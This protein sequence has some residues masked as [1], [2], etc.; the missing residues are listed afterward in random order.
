MFSLFISTCGWGIKKIILSIEN[1]RVQPHF[2]SPRIKGENIEN[3]NEEQQVVNDHLI[4]V[5]KS[6][7]CFECSLKHIEKLHKI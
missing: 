7:E 4:Q 6:Q 1:Q 3:G 5:N 2:I